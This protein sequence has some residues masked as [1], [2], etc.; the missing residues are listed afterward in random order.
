[1]CCENSQKEKRNGEQNFLKCSILFSNYLIWN[2]REL[3]QKNFSDDKE[4][5]ES[6]RIFDQSFALLLSC[7]RY[8]KNIEDKKNVSF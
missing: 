7:N 2:N 6:K 1:M 4:R 5:E 3:R 8:L